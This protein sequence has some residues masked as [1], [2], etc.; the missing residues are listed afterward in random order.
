MPTPT[1]TSYAVLGLLS[2]RS[3]TAYE[4]ARQSERSLRW[5]FPRAERAVYL[6]AKRL[7]DLGWARASAA[8]TGKRASTV[9]AITPAGEKALRA[10][11]GRPS[12]E[13]EIVSE[14]ALKLFFAD[15]ATPEQMRAT[16]KGMSA[17]A[18]RAVEHLAALASR[19]SQFPERMDTNILSM[20]LIVQIHRAVQ[21]WAQ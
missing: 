17:D 14:A 10:W 4:L 13:T 1:H 16:V 6:E 11:L 18:T 5:F 15:R 7:V 3:W 20:R 19:E 21:E 8:S 2:V 9:Y 12:D